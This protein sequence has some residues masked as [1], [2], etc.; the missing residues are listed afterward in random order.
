MTGERALWLPDYLRKYGLEPVLVDGW[1]A[2]G[3]NCNFRGS[4][5][6]HTAGP[7]KGYLPSLKTLINGRSDLSGP[8]CNVALPRYA[9]ESDKRVYVVAAGRANH[10]GVGSWKNLEGNSSVLGLEREHTG[11]ALELTTFHQFDMAAAVH[12]A[13]ADGANFDS[14][15]V[16][17]HYEWTTRKIDYIHEAGSTL[18]ARVQEYLNFFAPVVPIQNWFPTLRKG[19]GPTESV[20]FV[21]NF[22][23]N[24]AGQKKVKVDGIFG[25]VTEEAVKNV[26][27]FFKLPVDGIVGPKTWEVVLKFS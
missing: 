22:L 23:R 19:K 24:K 17:Q 11:S 21:Q 13:F 2:R 3:G 6:H 15:F 26:Q 7:A 25:S 16:C 10:A 1:Q 9:D 14:A 27:R 18:R 8:L 12:A 4:V 20:K 5:N